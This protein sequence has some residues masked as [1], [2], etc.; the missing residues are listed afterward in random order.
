MT[1]VRVVYIFSRTLL[2]DTASCMTTVRVVFWLVVAGANLLWER[3]TGG[4]MM[5]GA[6]LMWEKNTV[7]WLQPN[8]R[9]WF[10]PYLKKSSMYD[11]D[12][13]SIMLHYS[14]KRTCNPWTRAQNGGKFRKRGRRPVLDEAKARIWMGRKKKAASSKPAGRAATFWN[15]MFTWTALHAAIHSHHQVPKSHSWER[16]GS[17]TCRNC[18][19]AVMGKTKR[20]ACVM[21]W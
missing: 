19:H 18:K 2:C 17:K 13:E 6:G 21:V 4:W 10:I 5:A 1:T 20:R 7:S 8:Y 9:G 16:N 12:N 3:N 15:L 11:K 14:M